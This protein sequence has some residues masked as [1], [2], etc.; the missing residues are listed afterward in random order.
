MM[1][2]MMVMMRMVRMM[3]MV[4]LMIMRM[5]MM[6]VMVMMMLTMVAP[7]AMRSGTSPPFSVLTSQ[8]ET[9]EQKT[10]RVSGV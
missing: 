4:M 8:K 5:V 10:I 3:V 2:V 9:Q 7:R 1:M 6:M